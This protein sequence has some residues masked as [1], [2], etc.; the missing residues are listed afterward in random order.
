MNHGLDT[1]LVAVISASLVIWGLASAKLEDANIT[2][3]MI[4]IAAGLLVTHG[5]LAFVTIQAGSSQV[6]SLAEITLAVVLFGD[7][8]AVDVHKLR[9]QA[10]LPIRLLLI[11]LPL[12]VLIGTFAAYLLVPGLSI[13]VCAVIAASVAPTDAALGAPVVEDHRVPADVRRVLNVESGLNDGIVAPFVTF[14]LVIAVG[15]TVQKAPSGLHALGELALGALIGAV[16]GAGGG[17]LL[18][19]A[20]RRRWSSPAY[21]PLAVAALGLLAYGTAVQWHGNGFV[22]AFVAGIAFS[23]VTHSQED[24]SPVFEHRLGELLSFAVW[25]IF[26]AAVVPALQDAT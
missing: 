17:W 23:T 26:G 22:S 8:S 25:F 6:R 14:F 16:V 10:S 21:R 24:H 1:Q 5:P 4:F 11:G 20:Q 2:A 13:W 3:P 15:E 7:A 18:D 12:T 19:L 9:A